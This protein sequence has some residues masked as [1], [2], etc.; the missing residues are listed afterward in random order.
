MSSSHN[1]R[2]LNI[3]IC[4]REFS[5]KAVTHR[6][7]T[8]TAN[9]GI[10][11]DAEISK[12]GMETLLRV[13]F[14]ISE[15]IPVSFE[16]RVWPPWNYR[17]SLNPPNP[18]DYDVQH[19]YEDVTDSIKT[20][21]DLAS[22]HRVLFFI[23]AKI[24]SNDPM[25]KLME[26]YYMPVDIGEFV[27]GVDQP[28]LTSNEYITTPYTKLSRWN[29]PPEIEQRLLGDTPRG[30]FER[31]TI[32]GTFDPI[33]MASLL[34]THIANQSYKEDF[35][36]D[37]KLDVD[38]DHV[39]KIIGNFLA[40]ELLRMFGD[41]PIEKVVLRRCEIDNQIIDFHL[42]HHPRTLQWCLNSGIDFVGGNLMYI[43]GNE[44]VIA[45]RDPDTVF[46]H[47]NRIVHGVSKMESGV[48]YSLYILGEM[49]NKE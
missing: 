23:D 15:T 14:N 1:I 13:H 34:C 49:N 29:A 8:H 9:I 44:L 30:K 48:R 35:V 40:D 42:D 5:N 12:E 27:D 18:N 45:R 22:Y 33:E 16:V 47:D 3:Y 39:R 21:K 20:I 32:P 19:A 38:M 2:T 25:V 31:I 7:I 17:R 10:D 43:E 24:R 6:N 46:I 11:S 4:S 36:R 37:Y 28:I 26:V 41:H